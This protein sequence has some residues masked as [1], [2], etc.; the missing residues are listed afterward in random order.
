MFVSIEQYNG[1]E[2]TNKLDKYSIQS[3]IHYML[4][5]ITIIIIIIAD[6]LILCIIETYNILYI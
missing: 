3:Y 4:T 5:R 2:V 1:V 6:D